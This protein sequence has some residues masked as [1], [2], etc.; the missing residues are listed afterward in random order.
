MTEA[1]HPD[2][3]RPYGSEP[4]AEEIARMRG[5]TQAEAAAVDVMLLRQCSPRFQKVAMIVGKLLDDFD[6]RFPHLP[7]T[8][9]Q[10]RLQELED[11]GR[12]EIAGDVWLMRHSEVRL[13]NGPSEA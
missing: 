13:L 7:F 6:S 1:N 5:A 2:D 10:A 4:T 11:A 8:Y 12:I 3:E 9:M